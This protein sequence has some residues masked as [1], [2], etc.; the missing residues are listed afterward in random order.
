MSTAIPSHPAVDAC[1]P[2]ELAPSVRRRAMMT[3]MGGLAMSTLDTA[4]V[5]TGLPHLARYFS[6]DPETIIF[7]MSAYQAAMVATLVPLSALGDKIGHRP[8]YLTGLAVFVAGLV[9]SSLAWSPAS[10]IVARALQGLGAAG[11][12]SVSVALVRTVYPPRLLGRG[13]G[14]NALVVSS[15]LCLGPILASLLLEIASWRWLFLINLPFGALVIA[16]AGRTLPPPVANA[17][18]FDVVSA[19]ICTLAFTLVALVVGRAVAH[20]Q[21]IAGMFVA[22]AVLIAFLIRRD[23][24][25]PAPLLAVDLLKRPIFRL[26]AITATLTFAAHGIGLIVLPFL[27]TRSHGFGAYEIGF[28]IALWPAFMALSAP[29]A[30][31]LSDRL[32]PALLGSMGLSVLALGMVCLAIVPHDATVLDLAWRIALC[33]IG[34]GFFQSP[35]LRALMHNT[36]PL[37][38]GA[39]SG[40]V[41]IT[42]LVGQLGG[43]GISTASF[44][45]STEGAAIALWVGALLSLLGFFFST[46]RLFVKDV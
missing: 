37:R 16:A 3:L 12:M 28:L 44:A 27:I 38:S 30:G 33:G 45:I 46:L 35:N 29:L 14:I 22:A 42:R 31:P 21:A 18:R 41:A 10:L 5:S 20:W 36:P 11:I 34:F 13:M 19:M 40:V 2:G 17:H 23:A 43:A 24:H 15:F 4:A 25:N 1:T 9:L 39:A 26:S 32:S 8:I 6:A 7:V